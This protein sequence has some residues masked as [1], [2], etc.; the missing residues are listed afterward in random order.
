[1][2]LMEPS[3]DKGYSPMVQQDCYF[4]SF[5]QFKTHRTSGPHLITST[6]LKCLKMFLKDE[7]E[8]K[9]LLTDTWDKAGL[10]IACKFEA[11]P[12]LFVE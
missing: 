11:V 1:M 3:E 12:S 8:N 7:T 4:V 6:Y 5:S 9:H 10:N 2:L